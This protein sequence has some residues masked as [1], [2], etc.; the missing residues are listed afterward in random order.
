MR[1]L[2]LV[3]AMLHLSCERQTRHIEQVIIDPNPNF[4]ATFASAMKL[5]FLHRYAVPPIPSIIVEDKVEIGHFLNSIDF[6]THNKNEILVCMCAG[7]PVVNITLANGHVESFT[8]HH[9]SR[10]RWKAYESDLHM[11][12]NSE[13]TFKEFLNRHEIVGD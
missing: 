8:L 3:V 5:E 1:I 6:E 9:G 13:T 7:D 10:V 4:Q 2:V 12:H 11:T